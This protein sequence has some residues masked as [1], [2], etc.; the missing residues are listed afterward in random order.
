MRW[1]TYTVALLLFTVIGV[2]FTYLLMRVQHG[3]PFNPANLPNVEPR[4]GF[5]T[6]ISF[7]TNTNWQSYVPEVTMSYLSNMFALASHNFMSAA[8]GIAIAIAVLRGFARRSTHE[9][10]NFWVDVAVPA[11]Y[12]AAGLRCDHPDLRLAG[13]AA[14]PQR[15]HPRDHAIGRTADDRPAGSDQNAGHQRQ[16]SRRQFGAP[17]RESDA[18]HQSDPDVVDLRHP[19]RYRSSSAG[20]S[21]TRNRDGRF[22]RRWA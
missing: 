17:V 10:G 8:T 7:S 19:G 15:L 3:L 2:L 9:L 11:L 4:L 14:E 18:L 1:T 12:P 5:N 6:A 20:W 13:R 16:R 22:S 21:A